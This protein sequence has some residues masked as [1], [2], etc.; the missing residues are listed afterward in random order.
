MN[1]L[2][3]SDLKCVCDFC[4]EMSVA[5]HLSQEDRAVWCERH[6]DIEKELVIRIEKLF[7]PQAEVMFANTNV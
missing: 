2:S 7:N 6:M 5:Y 3:I 1:N 4:F